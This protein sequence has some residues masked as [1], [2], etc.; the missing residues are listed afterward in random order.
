MFLVML[1]LTLMLLL[2]DMSS[3]NMAQHETE[4]MK[5]LKEI[6]SQ[7]EQQIVNTSNQSLELQQRIAELQKLDIK[8][9]PLRRQALSQEINE[10]EKQRKQL[11]DA[12][13]IA[14]QDSEK[15]TLQAAQLLPILQEKKLTLDELTASNDSKQAEKDKLE[16][17]AKSASRMMS[18]TW[19]KNISQKPMLIECAGTYIRAGKYDSGIPIKSFT[20]SGGK[21][22]TQQ[23][24]ARFIEWAKTFSPTDYYFVLLAKPSSFEYAE[25][26]AYLLG[27]EGF[28]RGREI[29][30]ADDV[31]I[32]D[33]QAASN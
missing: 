1:I 26:I 4:E 3:R 33:G 28:Q 11:A 12:Q 20:C 17:S 2:R 29:L 30:P 22:S 25:I 15:Q 9:I 18:F 21:E 16:T 14:L 27:K 8:T 10:L 19:S 5:Q 24:A 13:A 7:L 31:V 23:M 32:F 6:I